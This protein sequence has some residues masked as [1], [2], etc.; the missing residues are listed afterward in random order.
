VAHQTEVDRERLPTGLLHPPHDLLVDR[1]A[2][3]E[4]VEVGGDE[5]VSLTTL[6]RLDGGLEPGPVLQVG[7]AADVEFLVDG[8]QV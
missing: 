4:A 6:Y 2:A 8:D 1:V 5:N 3:E 7:A